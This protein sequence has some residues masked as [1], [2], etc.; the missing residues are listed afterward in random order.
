MNVSGGLGGAIEA[1]RPWISTGGILGLLT[2]A[3]K[4]YL[5]NR[6]LRLQ[7][8]KRAQEYQLEVSADGRSNLQFII[9]N[10]RRDIDRAD[11]RATAAE[12]RASAA[13]KAHGACEQELDRVRDEGRGTRDR[14]EGLA[15]QFVAFADSV[16]AGIP[17]GTWSPEMTNMMDQLKGLGRIA[18]DVSKPA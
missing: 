3:A 12:T 8:E 13:E 6:K 5:D 14:L 18:R 11:R 7:A 1:L 15:R 17:P 4:L 10:L 16:A 9:D 2:F